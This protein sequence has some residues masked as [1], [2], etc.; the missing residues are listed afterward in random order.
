MPQR[1]PEWFA[2]RAGHLTGSMVGEW[3]TEGR[4]VRTTIDEAK[5]YLDSQGVEYKK[6]GNRDYFLGLLPPEM[7]VPSYSKEAESAKESAI[8]EILEGMVH[9]ETKKDQYPTA[10][11]Q[12]GTDLEPL[13]AAA[14][15]DYAECELVH[16]GFCES[17]HGSFGCSPDGFLKGT[18]EGLE[19]KCLEKHVRSLRAGVVPKEYRAQIALSLAVTGAARWHYWGWSPVFPPLHVVVERDNSIDMLLENLIAFSSDLEAAKQQM[20]QSWEDWAA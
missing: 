3:L 1:S 15:A 6:A 7:L 10:A 17:I 11:M 16:V 13:A 14:F 19:I 4:K 5:V 12:R 2:I 9:D 20:A 8:C 18:N